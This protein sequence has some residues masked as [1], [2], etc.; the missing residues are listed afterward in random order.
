LGEALWELNRVTL[1]GRRTPRLHEI[2]LRL[3]A[4]RTAVL[5][6]SGA[7]KSSLCHLLVGYARPDEGTIR[8]SPHG[9]E[10]RPHVFWAPQQ[11]GLWPH[12]TAAAHLRA[13]CPNGSAREALELLDAFDL[14]DLTQVRPA[15]MSRG[16]AARLNVARALASRARVVVLDEPLAHV[17]PARTPRYWQVIREATAASDTSLVFATHRPEPVLAEADKVVCL[18]QGELLYAGPVAPLY[19]DPPNERLARC[20][21]ETNWMEPDEARLWLGQKIERPRSVRPEALEVRVDPRGSCEVRWERFQGT[22]AQVG[23]CHRETGAER[24]FLHRPPGGRLRAGVRVALRAL[25]TV[26]LALVLAGCGEDEEDPA[27]EVSAVRAWR[28]PPDGPLAPAPRAVALSPEG[29]AYVLDT[30]GRVLVFGPEGKVRR[31]WRM[32]ETELGKPEGVAVLQDG[33]VAVADTHYHRVVLFDRT[34]AQVG[35]FGGQG[36]EP[37]QF[38]YPVGVTQDDEGHIYVAE[39]GSN[40]RVQKFTAQGEFVLSFGRFGTEEGAFQRPSGLAWRAGRVYVADAINNRI[41]VYTDEGAYVGE[42]GGDARPELTFPYD[43]VFGPDEALW[44]VEYGAGRLTKLDRQGRVLGRFG[45]RGRGP[46]ELCTPWG[47]AADAKRVLV[48]D[49]GNRRVLEVVP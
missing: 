5:G 9:A 43:A 18:D 28:L 24:T 46:R 29:E 22:V 1:R 30:V 42:L 37:G 26:L 27:L 33:R 14:Q 36:R 25:L 49:T 34:G 4:G 41:Q 16:E 3:D 23:L 17:D 45:G 13:V 11:G 19:A 38:L 39:Y 47:L 8:A 32:P 48:M 10:G 6:P 21:G 20:L 44:V 7:G 31:S 35:E 2:A 40:D 15:H 12:L